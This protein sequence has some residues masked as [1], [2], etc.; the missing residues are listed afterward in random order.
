MKKHFLI[1]LIISISFI[2]VI[3]IITRNNNN[4]DN[5][6]YEGK[7]YTL[8]K[9][10]NSIFTYYH[11]NYQNNYYEEDMIHK[12]PHD[13]WDIIYFNGDLYILNKQVKEANKYY[14]D[15]QNYD[16]YVDFDYEDEIIRE[17]IKLTKNEISNLYN[18]ESAN[19]D[20]TII[21]DDIEMFADILKISKDK[22]VQAL[23]VVAKVDNDWYYKT[24]IM[25]DE[26]REYVVKIT[27]SIN[28]KIKEKEV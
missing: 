13:K 6:K 12:V 1:L 22:M 15:D 19:R 7:K 18:L 11:T 21:F 8:L 23:I 20:K 14:A 5:I 4:I 25:T 9:Y 10:N 27:D 3:F 26:D 2:S 24:E 17:K 16:W 28:Q